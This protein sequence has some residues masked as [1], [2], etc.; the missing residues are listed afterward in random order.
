MA[1]KIL[2]VL[3]SVLRRLLSVRLPFARSYHSHNGGCHKKP[4]LSFSGRFQLKT[5]H[6]TLQEEHFMFIKG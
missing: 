2:Q 1:G 3:P 5:D 4:L 6:T